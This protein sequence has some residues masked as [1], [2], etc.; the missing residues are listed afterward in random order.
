M[1]NIT[2]CSVAGKGRRETDKE[3]REGRRER[4]R[5]REGEKERE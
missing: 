4:R 1:S 2:A 3:G 5:R